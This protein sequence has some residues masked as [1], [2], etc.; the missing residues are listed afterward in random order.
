MVSVK[1]K[2]DTENNIEKNTENSVVESKDR[3]NHVPL[4]AQNGVRYTVPQTIDLENMC[5]EVT[6]RFR[7]SDV[8]KDR[9]ISLYYHD[10]RV[11]HK[12]KKE[13]APG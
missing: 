3:R 2:S 6:V 12:K 10:V 7:V 1:G 11:S 4:L 5:E 13:L 8:Y 9:Y